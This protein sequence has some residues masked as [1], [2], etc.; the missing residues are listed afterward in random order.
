MCCIV[1]HLTSAAVTSAEAALALAFV[2]SVV[3]LFALSQV[4][5]STFVWTHTRRAAAL[6]L[7]NRQRSVLQH[8]TFFNLD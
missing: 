7:G 1:T 2:A 4:V 3:A 5:A 8:K 6:I